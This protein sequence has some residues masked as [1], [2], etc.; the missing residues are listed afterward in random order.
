MAYYKLHAYLYLV[1][2]S[3]VKKKKT[4]KAYLE[5]TS[6]VRKMSHQVRQHDHH[7]L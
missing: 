1:L 4:L 2:H 3:H 6:Y 5:I 7:G